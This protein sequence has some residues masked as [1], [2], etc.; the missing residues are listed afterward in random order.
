MRKAHDLRRRG[1]LATD[2]AVGDPFFGWDD[3]LGNQHCFCLFA[4]R[5]EI[6]DG[7]VVG[8]DY[9]FVGATEPMGPLAFGGVPEV[10]EPRLGKDRMAYA[11]GDELTR[12]QSPMP[13]E[14]FEN[15]ADV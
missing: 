3:A 1:A 14:W 8:E 5:V 15:V 11:E 13:G 2:A 9:F 7:E 10:A 12:G 6:L 4:E